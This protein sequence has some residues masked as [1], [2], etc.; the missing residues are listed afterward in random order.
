MQE[1]KYIKFMRGLIMQTSLPFSHIMLKRLSV[2][3]SLQI[4]YTSKET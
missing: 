1:K 3:K 4:C 2:N